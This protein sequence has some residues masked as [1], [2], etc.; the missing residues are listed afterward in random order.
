MLLL[1]LKS[2]L[3][4]GKKKRKIEKR[5][6]S[7]NTAIK[8]SRRMKMSG[9]NVWQ[10]HLCCWQRTDCFALPTNFFFLFSLSFKVTVHG[11][12]SF[13]YWNLTGTGQEFNPIRPGGVLFAQPSKV[14]WLL[15][16]SGWA[17]PI[18]YLMVFQIEG[19]CIAHHNQKKIFIIKVFGNLNLLKHSKYTTVQ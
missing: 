12:S 7:R 9:G 16:F 15:I 18:Q 19:I 1:P 2:F 17:I 14:N 10:S 11:K 8:L 4:L 6:K 3:F 5:R 13:W